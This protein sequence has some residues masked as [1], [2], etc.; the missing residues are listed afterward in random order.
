MMTQLYPLTFDPV[1][2]SYIWG[3]RNLESRLGRKIPPGVVAESW[4]ISGHADAPTHVANGPLAG[5]SLPQLLEA[6][7]EQLVGSRSRDMLARG[8]FPLLVKL[9]DA[10]Q[11]LSVQ[12]HPNNDYAHVHENGDLGKTE[13]WYILHAE[14]GAEL[15]YGLKPNVTPALFRRQLQAGALENCLHRLPV[16]AGDAVFIPAGSIHAIMDGIVLAEIQQSSNTTYRVYDWNRVDASGKSRPL[17]I[18]KAMDVINFEQVEPGPFPPQVVETGPGL[19]RAIISQS[20][21]FVVERLTFEQPGAFAGHC[22]GSTFE[23]WGAM[24]GSGQIQWAGEPLSLAAVH[25]ALLPAALGQ[26]E[27]SAEQPSQ[28]LRAYVPA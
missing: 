22:D 25:F 9:L 14:P 4:E 16:K 21:Y 6:L 20:N 28:W 5:Q 18:D 13:M 10:N 19:E 2:Q 8:K 1:F 11:P 12:V 17:H 23:I 7:G 26:F 3:G 24:Q 15:I 27:I